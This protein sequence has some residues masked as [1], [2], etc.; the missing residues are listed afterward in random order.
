MLASKIKALPQDTFHLSGKDLNSKGLQEYALKIGE[1]LGIEV[2]CVEDLDTPQFIPHDQKICLPVSLLD[3][4]LNERKYREMK[5]AID[6]EFAHVLW[7]DF[8]YLNGENGTVHPL[9]HDIGTM[10]DDIRIERRM[11]EKYFIDPVNFRYLAESLWNTVV[12]Q[13]NKILKNDAMTSLAL[14]VSIHYR[15]VNISVTENP[16]EYDP[17]MEQLFN[18]QIKNIIDSF[19]NTNNKAADVASEIIDILQQ[20]YD[21]GNEEHPA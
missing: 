7:P 19:I 14:L 13:D 16:L 8:S 11:A 10:I 4:N 5:G 3:E 2:V 6:H 1:K 15:E 9:I 12:E 20:C 18:K 21:I 17:N